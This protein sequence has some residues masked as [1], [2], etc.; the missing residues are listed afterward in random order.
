MIEILLGLVLL[1]QIGTLVA[2]RHALKVRK[3]CVV[4][5]DI[6]VADRE[7]PHQDDANLEIDPMLQ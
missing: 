2:I 6:R 1:F 5:S 3:I 4:E 7:T